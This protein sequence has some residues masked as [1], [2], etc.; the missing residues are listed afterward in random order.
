MTPLPLDAAVKT[1]F[2]N[3]G[4]T[5][6]MLLLAIRRGVLG[7]EKIGRAYFVTEAD[8]M[9]WRKTCR[10][11]ATQ[12]GRKALSPEASGAGARLRHPRRSEGGRHRMRPRRCR[13]C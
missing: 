10:N 3:G 5:K 12:Q 11:A 2:P 8:V 6:N 4:V 9:Q 13:G 7:F 1:F